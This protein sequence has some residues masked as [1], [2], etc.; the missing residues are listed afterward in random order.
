MTHRPFSAAAAVLALTLAATS[1]CFAQTAT[2]APTAPAMAP[3]ASAA[4]APA[5]APAA[6]DTSAATTERPDTYTIQQGDT[7]WSISHKY[8]T[9]IKALQKLNNLKKHQLLHIGQVI[10]IPPATPAK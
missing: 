9:S 5:S 10:K 2:N 8:D 7:L 1:L 4:P 3:A 6:T